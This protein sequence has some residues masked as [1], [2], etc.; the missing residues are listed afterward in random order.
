MC[1]VIFT[2]LCWVS[3]VYAVVMCLCV[4]LSHSGIVSKWLNLGSRKQRYTIAKGL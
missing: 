4:C 1:M 2:A 3:A